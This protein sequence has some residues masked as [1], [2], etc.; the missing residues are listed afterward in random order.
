M[1]QSEVDPKQL[2]RNDE[3]DF[4]GYAETYVSPPP[5]ETVGAP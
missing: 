1:Q 5:G 3:V 4:L 2:Q